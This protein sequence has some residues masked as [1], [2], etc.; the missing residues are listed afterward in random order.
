VGGGSLEG[1]TTES[2]NNT[3]GREVINKMSRV[4]FCQFFN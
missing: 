3:W 4:I 1:V 2:P